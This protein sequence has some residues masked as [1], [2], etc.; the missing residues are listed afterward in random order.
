MMNGVM[1]SGNQ[2]P[3]HGNRKRHGPRRHLHP[4]NSGAQTKRVSVLIGKHQPIGL[5]QSKR[6]S[7]LNGRQLIG[8]A[9][10]KRANLMS[11]LSQLSLCSANA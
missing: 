7:V 2:H 8:T 10:I 9:Q 11:C 3:G 5:A 1:S 4:G 6:V